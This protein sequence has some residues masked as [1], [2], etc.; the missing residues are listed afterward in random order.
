[1]SFLDTIGQ[2][3]ASGIGAQVSSAEAQALQVAK[4]IAVWGVIVVVE[5]GILIFVLTKK[6][7]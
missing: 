2:G 6:P 3:I 1:M 5:L 4:A 7:K